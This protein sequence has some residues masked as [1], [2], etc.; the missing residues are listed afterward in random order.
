MSVFIEVLVPPLDESKLRTLFTKA[1]SQES[2]PAEQWRAVYSDN[3]HFTDPTQEKHG[4]ESYIKAQE[5]LI[6]RCDD[7]FLKAGQIVVQGSIAFVEW[8]MGLKIK[9]IE[10]VYLGT[11][12]LSFGTD[13]RIIEHQDYFDFIGPTFKPVPILG[14]FVRWLYRKFVS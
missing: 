14:P 4:I 7:I 11:T 3:V 10:F 6:R 2:P 13:G 12:R 8:E 9:G 1:Y 5:G